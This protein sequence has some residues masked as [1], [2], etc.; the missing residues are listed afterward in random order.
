VATIWDSA[1]GGLSSAL[2]KAPLTDIKIFKQVTKTLKNRDSS[3][4]RLKK[5]TKRLKLFSR[6]HKL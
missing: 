3:V 2:I 5:Q 6:G 4:G 1:G